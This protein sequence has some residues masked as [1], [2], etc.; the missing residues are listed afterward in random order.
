MDGSI[1]GSLLGLASAV[2]YSAMY[3]LVRAGV[4]RTD[5]DGGAFVTTVVNAVLLVATLLVISVA[6]HPPAWRPEA[7]IW[8]SVAGFL[9]TFSGRVFMLAGLRRIGPVRTAS[10]VNT[11]PVVTIGISVLVLG[12]VLS[13]WAI[14]AAALVLTGLGLLAVDAFSTS[15][16]MPGRSS[17]ERSSGELS[18]GGGRPARE[19]RPA[20]SGTPGTDPATPAVFGLL[21]STL[22]ATSF[23]TARIARRIGFDF[24][25][26]PVVGAM[27]GST[28][29]LV[30]NVILQA[31]QG[32]IRSVV[33]GS[34]RDI[35]PALWA[36]GVCSTLGLVFFFA[37]LQFS[38]L[39]HVAVVT[40]S[41]T[42]ITM[43][44]S[45]VLFPQRESLSPRVL[46]AASCVFGAGV[47]IALS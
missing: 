35:R 3:F 26:D 17:G 33:L 15:E 9:G 36:A 23:G 41:E 27:V 24:L 38:P 42:V 43:L 18:S 30:S 19:L 10:I 31:R 46:V 28:A 21:L 32:R 1:V 16:G 44:M 5:I 13:G 7:L 11:A 45:R 14:G 8:F 47:M 22:S 29:A 34:F 6:G 12:E 39:S 40:A 2:A 37:A 25:P 20:A 4:R